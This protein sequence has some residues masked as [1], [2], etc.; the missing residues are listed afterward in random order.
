[1]LKAHSRCK[2]GVGFLWQHKKGRILRLS[3]ISY[4]FP[5]KP[6]S[7]SQTSV[8]S[9]FMINVVN[10]GGSRHDVLL[11]FTRFVRFHIG[12]VIADGTRR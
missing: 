6:C 1:M 3:F 7:H 8:I 4:T 10:S 2:V 5:D 11:I 12:N 9:Q